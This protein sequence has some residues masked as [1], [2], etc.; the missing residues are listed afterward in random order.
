MTLVIYIYS[1]GIKSL[2][3]VLMSKFSM[4]HEPLNE[5]KKPEVKAVKHPTSSLHHE[6]YHKA[7]AAIHPITPE[8]I[9]NSGNDANAKL[10]Y[11]L[12]L[13][14]IGIDVA[15]TDQLQAVMDKQTPEQIRETQ[16]V[17]DTLKGASG[18]VQSVNYGDC[19]FESSLSSLAISHQGQELI[20]K[21]ISQNKDGSYTVVF[22]GYDKL[23]INVT[24]QEIAADKLNNP[25]RWANILETA[26]IKILPE[27]AKNGLEPQVA[28]KLLTDKNTDTMFLKGKEKVGLDQISQ[29][30]EHKLN[31]GEP[32][33]AATIAKVPGLV[34]E[35]GPIF[36]D[37]SYSVVGFNPETQTVI[38]RNP[39][40]L[41]H[42]LPVKNADI[43]Q[44]GE[45][46]NGIKNLGNGEISMSLN[47]F[48]KAYSFIAFTKDK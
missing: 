8:Q 36:L 20:S 31:A 15:P 42:N 9:A 4:Q 22:P 16:K 27:Q 46:A 34:G 48:A 44:V 6:V 40:G 21:M 45:V 10:R 39:F 38:L 28:L 43:P 37:H 14:G 17:T 25:T 23:K 13:K 26:L 29:A 18:V 7:I 24:N 5:I 2:V 47:Q 30:L 3:R 11:S 32:V 33:V 19:W 41:N 1:R 12:N 35:N